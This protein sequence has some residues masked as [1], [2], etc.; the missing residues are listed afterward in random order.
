V[1]FQQDKATHAPAWSLV[2]LFFPLSVAA[3]PA[4]RTISLSYQRLTADPA[5]PNGL[6]ISL[7]IT[8]NHKLPAPQPA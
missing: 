5:L 1:F 4:Y 8:I 7:R 2:N 3:E 6:T